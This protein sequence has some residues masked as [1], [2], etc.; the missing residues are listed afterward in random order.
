MGDMSN[1]AKIREEA[2]ALLDELVT[3]L[4]QRRQESYNQSVQSALIRARAFLK[5]GCKP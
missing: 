2:V 4:D 1:G 3:L 5:R